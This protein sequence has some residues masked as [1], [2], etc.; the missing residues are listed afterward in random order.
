MHSRINAYSAYGLFSLLLVA[1]GLIIRCYPTVYILATYEDL[2]GEWCQFYFFA[3][4]L[5]FS[6]RLACGPS[7]FRVFFAALALACFYVTGEEISWGQRLFNIPSPDFFRLHNL[8]Q[9]TNLHNFFTGPGSTLLKRGIEAT[10]AG[11][12]I[13]YGVIYPRELAIGRAPALRI[14]GLG[15]PAPPLY[16][17]PFFMAAALCELRLFSFN[18][19]EIAEMLLALALAML[20]AHYWLASHRQGRDRSALPRREALFFLLIFVTGAGLAAATSLLC[21]GVP[22]LQAGMEVRM[23]SGMEKFAHRY[24]RYGSWENAAGLYRQLLEK[25]QKNADLLRGLARCY[26]QMGDKERFAATSRQAIALDMTRYGRHPADVAVNLSL[27]KTFLLAGFNE[28]ADRHLR[29]A[30]QAGLSK[31]NLEPDNATAVYWLGKSYLAA[32]DTAQAREMLEKAV[33]LQPLSPVYRK[34]LTRLTLEHGHD[35]DQDEMETE[36]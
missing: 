21:A 12:F 17:W 8:Q 32:G 18:E 20:A 15:I 29:Q 16:L 35:P 3:I 14:N 27:H 6:L 23:S 13:I 36:G 2:P 28:Q 31:V 9:E 34:E 7:R 30:M 5:F 1:F 19:A 10:L 11:A 22:R 25:N 26:Q 24:A 33:R 4:T